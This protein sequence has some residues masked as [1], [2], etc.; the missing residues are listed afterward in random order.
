MKN[1]VFEKKN[2]VFIN[3]TSRIEYITFTSFQAPIL[4][5]SSKTAC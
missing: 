4:A 1:E 5:V 3:T 2:I